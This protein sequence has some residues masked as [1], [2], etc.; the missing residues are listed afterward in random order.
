MIKKVYLSSEIPVIF[1][2]S[3]TFH[4]FVLGIWIKHGSRHEPVSKNG[5]SHFIEHL[6]FQGTEKR[7][8]KDISL[9]IDSMGGDINAFTAREFT[10]LYIKVLNSSCI[11]AIELIG[12]IYSNPLFPDSEIEKERTIILDE[13]RTV[14]DTPDELVH[15]LFMEKAF[16]GGLGQPILGKEE[17]VKKISRKDIIDCFNKYYG[18]K[19]CI[20]SCCGNFDE[21]KVLSA[22][23]RYIKIRN[24]DNLA[25]PEKSIFKPSLTLYERDLS[26]VHLCMGLETFPFKNPKRYA[27]L[28]L[29]CIVGGSVSSKLFQEIRE[30]RGLVYNIYSFVS[31]YSETGIFGIYTACDKNK[32]N[33][34]LQLI[35]SIIKNLP[36]DLS[37]EELERAKKQAIS[38]ILFSTESSNAIM[39]NLAYQELYLE[40]LYDINK[41]IEQIKAVQLEE[42]K[43]VAEFLKEQKIATTVLGPITI[44]QIEFSNK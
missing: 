32:L 40:E 43:A 5:L 4:S 12:D 38:Q 15:D 37:L 6:F 18:A 8:A 9:Q 27:L 44:E 41:Q 21:K 22:L 31:H 25:K 17:T 10:S 19:N 14:N 36:D 24:C 26:E 2:K 3:R 16:P 11:E 34:I 13:I 20:I 35:N 42:L 23:E 30:K 7:T 33:R 39:Q 28:L 29:N 1:N